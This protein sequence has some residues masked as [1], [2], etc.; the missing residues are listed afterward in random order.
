MKRF[1]YKDVKR[2]FDGGQ[3]IFRRSSIF[4]LLVEIEILQDKLAHLQSERRWIPVSTPPGKR[5]FYLLRFY[6]CGC[7]YIADAQFDKVGIN[8]NRWYIQSKRV[9]EPTHWMPLPEK[10]ETTDE[11]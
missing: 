9:E 11:N 5:G 7:H 10:P 3:N 8:E 6:D 4:P 1:E 2:A